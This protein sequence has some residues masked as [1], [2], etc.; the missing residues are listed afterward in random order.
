MPKTSPPPAPDLLVRWIGRDPKT[1]SQAKVAAHCQCAQTTI[2]RLCNRKRPAETIR[3]SWAWAIQEFT[4]GAVPWW[5]W[6][7][8]HDPARD[9]GRMAQAC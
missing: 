6:W 7:T 5:S 3:A 2:F 4:G 9:G 8:D 1:R